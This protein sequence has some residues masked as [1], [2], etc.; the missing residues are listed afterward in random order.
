MSRTCPYLLV[1]VVSGSLHIGLSFLQDRVVIQKTP[2]ISQ[3]GGQFVCPGKVVPERSGKVVLST[4]S[5][6]KITEERV[7]ADLAIGGET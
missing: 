1:S 5:R 6:C 4:A 3:D 2:A 7:H